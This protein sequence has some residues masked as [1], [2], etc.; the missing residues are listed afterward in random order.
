MRS[1][2]VPE[3]DPEAFVRRVREELAGTKL[4]DV[5]RI[6]TAAGQL[7]VQFTRLGRS[8]LR[9]D[10]FQKESG[11]RARLA[12][13]RIAL[14][15]IPFRDAFDRNFGKLIARVGGRVD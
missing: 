3:G 13:E 15:H 1:F 9:Y 2:E 10:L 14:M 12:R 8:E 5:V 11:F 6:E 7:V 4:G